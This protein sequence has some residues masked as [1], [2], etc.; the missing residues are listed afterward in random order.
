MLLKNSSTDIVDK[1]TRGKANTAN[2]V[3][4]LPSLIVIDR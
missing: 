2:F 4:F 3:I 1:T